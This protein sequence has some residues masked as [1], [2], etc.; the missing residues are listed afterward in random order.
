MESNR[1]LWFVF[2][3]GLIWFG[4][5]WVERA[6]GLVWLGLIFRMNWLCSV[7]SSVRSDPGCCAPVVSRLELRAASVVSCLS[8]LIKPRR[9]D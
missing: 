8:A 4:A 3:F 1:V 6:G 7:P 9:L 5:K 2:S